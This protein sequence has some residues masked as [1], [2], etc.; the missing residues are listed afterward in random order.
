MS[1]QNEEE[2]RTILESFEKFI[3]SESGLMTSSEWSEIGSDEIVSAYIVNTIK[4]LFQDYE[5]HTVWS[6]QDEA[7]AHTFTEVD[8]FVEVIAAYLPGFERLQ[9]NDILKW[10]IGLKARIDEDKKIAAT[11]TL[12]TD[13]KQSNE[14]ETKTTS[15]TKIEVEDAN[16]ATADGDVKLLLEMF[17]QFTVKDI[18]KVYKKR[19]SNYNAAIDELVLLENASV[20]SSDDDVVYSN[21]D[22]T[23]EEKQL[24]KERTV[25]KFGFVRV[26]E[27]DPKGGD[28]ST[29][30]PVIKWNSEKKMVRYF[31]S[32]VVSTKGEKYFEPKT[33]KDE[34]LEKQMKSTYVNLKPARKYRFH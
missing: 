31:D 24:L 4:Q 32:K 12:T 8:A 17:P 5:D 16:E 23:E 9:V 30:K 1:I 29:V 28:I 15:I 22:L 11:A 7:V 27:D 19:G 18:K 10:L 3:T 25:Q 20:I 33:E 21:D 13:T 2:Q 26:N 6:S 14:N 34:E